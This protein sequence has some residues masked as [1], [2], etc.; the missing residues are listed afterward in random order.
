[1]GIRDVFYAIIDVFLFIFGCPIVG[2][3]TVKVQ[4]PDS[5]HIPSR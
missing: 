1:M 5:R 2:L 4:M 3:W